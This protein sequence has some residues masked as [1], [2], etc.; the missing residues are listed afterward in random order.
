LEVNA[1]FEPNAAKKEGGDGTSEA[2][3]IDWAQE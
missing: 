2:E 3:V 1:C